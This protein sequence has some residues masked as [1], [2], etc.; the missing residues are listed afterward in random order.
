MNDADAVFA[1]L[2]DGTRRELLRASA[3]RGPTTATQLAST[4]HI[5]RQAVAKHLSVLSDAGLVSGHRDGREV[6][7]HADT[8]PLAAA[9]EWIDAT[10]A[11]W[12]RR[13]GR[14]RDLLNGPE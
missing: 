9:R 12:D 3:T 13:L 5:T 11:A 6:R 8:E 1:A 7:F 2:A 14:L 10:G 4:R